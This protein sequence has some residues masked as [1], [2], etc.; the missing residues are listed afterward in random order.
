MELDSQRD[1]NNYIGFVPTMGSLHAGHLSLV[2]KSLKE[3]KLTVVSIFVN[4]TQFNSKKD[5]DSYPIQIEKDCYLLKNTSLDIVVFIPSI[6]QIYP[7]GLKIQQFNFN[8]L[9]RFM[10]GAFRKQHFHGVATVVNSLINIVNPTNAYFGKKDFQQFKIIQSIFKKHNIIGCETFRDNNGLALS[11]RNNLL[12]K[13]SKLL[14]S[15]IYSNLTFV[16]KN[17]KKF[18]V[19][20]LEEIVSDYINSNKNMKLEYF[21]IAD[22]NKLEPTLKLNNSIKYRSFIAV[23]VDGIRLIDNIALY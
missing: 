19:E 6:D 3:N 4:P 5:L 7:N 23:Y 17:I 15:K 12:S 14:A 10:E 18:S 8:G 9:D 11:S 13:K 16:K 2:K 1:L 20:K 21:V 22:E